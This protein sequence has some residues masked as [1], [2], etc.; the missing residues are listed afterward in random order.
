MNTGLSL[1]FTPYKVYISMKELA[2][3]VSFFV[4]TLS[5]GAKYQLP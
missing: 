2:A 5:R 3:L 4:Y 1:W